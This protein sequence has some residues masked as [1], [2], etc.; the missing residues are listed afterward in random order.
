MDEL[1][2][3]L[4]ALAV[5][6]SGYPAPA[7]VPAVRGL[8]VVAL[9]IEADAFHVGGLRSHAATAAAGDEG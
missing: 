4:L 5:A 7:S 1:V 6:W 2:A 3:Q 8:L 9:L